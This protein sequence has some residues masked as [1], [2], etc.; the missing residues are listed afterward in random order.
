MRTKKNNLR[1]S[2]KR[3]SVL[4]EY[5]L[6]NAFIGAAIVLLWHVCFYNEEKGWVASTRQDSEEA[7]LA[8]G[9]ETR[10]ADFQGA[11]GAAMVEMYRRVMTGI[12]MPFP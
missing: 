9:G 12:S 3:G 10:A 8:V 7:Q 6:I 1:A 4:M 2:S 11:D 5:C